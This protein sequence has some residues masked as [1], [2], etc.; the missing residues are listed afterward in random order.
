MV[1]R[2]LRVL[3]HLCQN[4]Q[5]QDVGETPGQQHRPNSTLGDDGRVYHITFYGNKIGLQFQKVPN[6]TKSIGLLTEAMTADHGQNVGT[7]QTAAELRRIASIS[8]H[9]QY[10]NHQDARTI[11]CLPATPADAVLVCGFIGFDDS[12]GNSRPQLGGK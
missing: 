9:S 4:P 6:E 7:K 11:E 3:R 1:S 8:L 12:T 2:L 5:D 10:R